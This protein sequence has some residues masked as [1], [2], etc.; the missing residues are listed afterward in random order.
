MNSAA[1]WAFF[2]ANSIPTVLP[3]TTGGA[4]HSSYPNRH[5]WRVE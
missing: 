5:D 2:S 1:D 4:W 3:F